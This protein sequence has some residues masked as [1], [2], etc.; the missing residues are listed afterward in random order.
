M[1]EGSYT[2]PIESLEVSFDDWGRQLIE[3]IL[4]TAA[5]RV[6]ERSEISESV[7]VQLTFRLK[8]MIS[9][10]QI[11]VSVGFERDPTLITY[12]PRQR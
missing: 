2:K 6:S 12:I 11:E 10:D 8:P 3:N 4:L 1:N 7:E 5:E 9:R